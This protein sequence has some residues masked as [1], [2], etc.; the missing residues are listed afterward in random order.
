MYAKTIKYVDYNGVER[1]EKFY[2]NIN[3]SELLKW[4]QTDGDFGLDDLVH[5]LQKERNGQ[6]IMDMFEDFLR[7][8]YGEKSLDGRL[9]V[10]TD[11]VWD[12]FRFSEAYNV[13]FSSLVLDAK[14]AAEFINNVI[15][16]EM[17]EEVAKAIRENPDG[18]P[19]ELKDYIV[20]T[21][22]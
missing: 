15:P 12:K 13:L 14:A 22:N 18:I 3:Q 16:A 9:F 7:R 21:N 8:T 11:E 5:K 17:A 19:E 1:E 2:F 4:M 10:K 6:K 20:D